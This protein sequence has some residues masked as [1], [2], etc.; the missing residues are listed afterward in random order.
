MK[1]NN[2]INNMSTNTNNVNSNNKITNT[3]NNKTSLQFI[4][5]HQN[6]IKVSKTPKNGY[7][8]LSGST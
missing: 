6:I 2:N 7:T 4:P 3:N 1:N 5:Q 8:K